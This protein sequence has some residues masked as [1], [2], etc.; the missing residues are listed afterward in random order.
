MSHAKEK[1]EAFVTMSISVSQLARLR[2]RCDVQQGGWGLLGF[3][4]TEDELCDLVR[5][6]DI[7]LVGYEKITER[8]IQSAIDLKLIGV[9]RA[10][11][12]N[13]NHDAVN[14]RKIPLIYTPGRNAIAAAEYTIGIMLTQAR[15]IISGDRYLRGGSYLGESMKE[16]F[17]ENPTADVIWDIDGDSPYTRLRGVELNGRTLGLVGLGNVAVRVASLAKAFG[18]HVITYTPERDS[19]RAA[20]LGINI[21]SLEQLLSESDFISIHCS[22][23]AET[24]AIIDASSFLQMK[25]TVYLINTARASMIDQKAL[26][27]A[28]QKKQ[29]AGAAL[30][31]FWYEPLPKNHPLLKMDNVTLTPHLAGATCEV[32]E[33]H[34]R[35][36]VDDVFSWMDGRIPRNVFNREFIS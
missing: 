36:L 1:L 35:M 10:N 7:L 18:M 13:V 22:V 9:S 19:D 15:N 6:A 14:A 23:T 20:K 30:D 28:L 8:V 17:R 31:V 2:S 27:N 16:I 21:V 4:S 34:S 5:S 12:I 24:K 29:I 26:I 25:P 3:R 32:P 11:P 33:R